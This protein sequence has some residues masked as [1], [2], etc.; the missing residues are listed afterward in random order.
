MAIRANI[1]SAD[2]DRRAGVGV[3]TEIGRRELAPAG[4][5]F[6]NGEP[7]TLVDHEHL[8]VSGN[9]RAEILARRADPPL[10]ER[11]ASFCVDNG[12]NPSRTDHEQLPAIVNGRGT[13]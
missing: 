5:C 13:I 9:R 7:A 4:G 12:E 1:D 8:T 10:F 3:F 6:E 2:G 11:L